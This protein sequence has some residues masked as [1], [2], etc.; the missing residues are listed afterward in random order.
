MWILL[1]SFISIHISSLLALGLI[2]AF[3]ATLIPLHPCCF[4]FLNSISV[5]EYNSNSQ[6]CLLQP[7]LYLY[8]GSTCLSFHPCGTP[9]PFS[10]PEYFHP[11]LPVK[12]HVFSKAFLTISMHIDFIPLGIHLPYK[13]QPSFLEDLL[14]ASPMIS[15][16]HYNCMRSLLSSSFYKRGNQ[17]SERLDN[18]SHALNY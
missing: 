11:S 4:V 10:L 2:P 13:L 16:P 7:I 14:S 1:C 17:G 15:I 9:F 5:I 3:F 6:L 8:L 18:L 12:S